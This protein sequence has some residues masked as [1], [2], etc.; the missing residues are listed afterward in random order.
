VVA[1]AASSLSQMSTLL[2]YGLPQPQ[3]KSRS[4]RRKLSHSTCQPVNFRTQ[5][6]CPPQTLTTLTDAGRP[7]KAMIPRPHWDETVVKPPI[8]LTVRSSTTFILATVS[9]AVFMDIFLFSVYP[10]GRGVYGS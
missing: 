9:V 10:V 1:V 7:P 2:L 3:S 5:S 6:S 8:F 4:S